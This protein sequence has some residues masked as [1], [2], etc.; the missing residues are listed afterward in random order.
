MTQLYRHYDGNGV[1]LYR[2]HQEDRLAAPCACEPVAPKNTG[3]ALARRLAKAQRRAEAA[4]EVSM[5]TRIAN[6][7][8]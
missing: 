8:A 4:G 3:K 1:L 5:E 7:L 6:N 2:Y